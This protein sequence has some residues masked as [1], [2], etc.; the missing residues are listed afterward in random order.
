MTIHG[1][2][3][4]TSHISTYHVQDILVTYIL[5][6]EDTNDIQTVSSERDGGS[7]AF[8]IG[9]ANTHFLANSARERGLKECDRTL[10]LPHSPL[11]L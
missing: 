3:A 5:N 9:P 1:S 8:N 2:I 4:L 11:L 7:N 10:T 6:K